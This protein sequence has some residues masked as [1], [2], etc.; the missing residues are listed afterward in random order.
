M[1]IYT[2]HFR[3][4][5]F[6]S[7]EGSKR[8]SF[9]KVPNSWADVWIWLEWVRERETKY[10]RG[11]VIT[12]HLF[13]SFPFAVENSMFF[14][15]N[16]LTPKHFVLVYSRLTLLNCWNNH[17]SFRWTTVI[18]KNYI[19][20]RSLQDQILV[21]ELKLEVWHGT[22][23]NSWKESSQIGSVSFYLFFFSFLL[24]CRR[25]TGASVAIMDREMPL[26]RKARCWTK[27]AEK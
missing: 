25:N 21:K 1:Y 11:W 2:W 8:S 20:Q 27:K 6:G 12:Q 19:S 13:Y 4:N 18:F 9:W 23:R 16:F 22:S 24:D 14:N 26:K 7:A 3:I 17:Q 5:I 15:F 10:G